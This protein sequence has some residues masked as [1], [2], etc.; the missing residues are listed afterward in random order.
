MLQPLFPKLSAVVSITILLIF[1]TVARS[2]IIPDATLS[3]SFRVVRQGNIR[4]IEG[5]TQRGSNLFHSFQEFSLPTEVTTY[6]NNS[7]AIENVFYHFK[8]G[9]EIFNKPRFHHLK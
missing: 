2:E 7:E 8:D 6:F 9:S 1:T 3:E 4:R 5:G